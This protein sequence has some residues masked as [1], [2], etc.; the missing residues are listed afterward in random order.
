MSGLILLS[1]DIELSPASRVFHM[2]AKPTDL[3]NMACEG[4]F[5]NGDVKAPQFAHTTVHEMTDEL[6]H[7][8]VRQRFMCAHPNQAIVDIAFQG[9][10][11]TLLGLDFYRAAQAYILAYAAQSGKQGMLL[12]QTNGTK[13]DVEWMHFFQDCERK[14]V[15]V[16]LGISIDGP[17]HLN[18]MFRVFR[19]G[20][21]AHADIMKA[22]N[23]A[24]TYNIPFQTMTTVNGYNAA[25]PREVYEF[26]RDECGAAFMHFIPVVERNAPGCP[27]ASPALM[28]AD[29]LDLQVSDSSVNAQDYGHFM[30]E[31]FKL[32]VAS[33]ME[34]VKVR[35]FDN[36]VGIARGAGSSSCI[37]AK[38]CGTAMTV[39]HLGNMFSCDHYVFPEYRLGNLS[40]MSMTEALESRQQVA[41]GN[42]KSDKLPPQC[43]KCPHLKHCNGGCPKNRFLQ[44]ERGHPGLNY[45]CPG[46]MT[47]FDYARPYFNAMAQALENA[48]SIT[49]YAN[50]LT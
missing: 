4:C 34:T 25:Y 19:G 49:E 37:F 2:H 29:E 26:L 40:E 3:C 46:Y 9:G 47:F 11:P 23:L 48:D 12:F 38:T 35:L 28:S 8:F 31:V 20:Q 10:E 16:A 43:T 13:L 21:G 27:I 22:I 32:W 5:Y 15:K 44:D 30:T 45:L 41:F 6:L 18:D 7:E 50:Y 42:A 14:G 33:D 36:H 39:D 1:S 17:A 24:R